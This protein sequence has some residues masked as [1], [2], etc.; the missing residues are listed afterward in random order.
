MTEREEQEARASASA[1]SSV[2]VSEMRAYFIDEF[3]LVVLYWVRRNLSLCPSLSTGMT[4]TYGN[5]LW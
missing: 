2:K 4:P 3:V 5:H 1:G